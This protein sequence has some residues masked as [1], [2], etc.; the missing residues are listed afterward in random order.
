MPSGYIQT[1][2]GPSGSAGN[3]YYT[4]VAAAGHN[5]FGYN[6]DDYQIPTC[7]PINVC[8][9]VTTPSGCSQTVTNLAGNTQ[10][11]D[12]VTATFT[13]PSGMN[14]QLTLL[15]LHRAGIVLQRLHRL[16][17]GDLSA[18]DR[19]LR[20]G[21]PFPDDPD[22]ELRLPGRLRLRPGDRPV[23][24]E[25]EQ[26]CLW[27]GRRQ[28]P[29]SC[30][31]SL[32]L[33]GQRRHTAPQPMPTPSPSPT[34]PAPDVEHRDPDRLGDPLG[35]I[36]P[37]RHDHLLPVRAGRDTQRH[38]QQQRLQRHGRGRRQRHLHH[39][40]RDQ[41]GRRHP[42]GGGHVPVGGGL[43]RRPQQQRGHRAATAASP[44]RSARPLRP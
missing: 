34:T 4:I 27:S 24:A 5:Y 29:L 10:Q 39:G 1:G 38:R 31:G 9:K 6:F 35:R 21:D 2:G 36:L 8:Y 20:A 14:D 40:N 13:V 28:Y 30:R 41:S 42:D 23:R 33:L 37:G 43:R 3:S 15:S 16:R 25:P 22:P 26:R 17:A 44:R 18:G 7:T 32:H 11:G 12:T 19:D